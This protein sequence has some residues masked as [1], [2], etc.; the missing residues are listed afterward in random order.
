M[1]ATSGSPVDDDRIAGM[2]ERIAGAIA[3]QRPSD[4]AAA[5]RADYQVAVDMI[6]VLSDIRFRCLVF[7]TSITALANALAPSQ[8]DALRGPLGL[9]GLLA[10]LGIAVY[11]LRNSQLY[12]AAMH[13]AKFLERELQCM[14]SGALQGPAGLFT[15]RPDYINRNAQAP[16]DI[17]PAEPPLMRF[18]LVQVKHDRGLALIYG[19]ALG[20]WAFLAFYGL[21]GWCGQFLVAA[22]CLPWTAPV[23]HSIRQLSALAVG[24]LVTVASIRM[25]IDHDGERWPGPRNWTKRSL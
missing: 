9:L 10:T 22:G 19:A 6:K 11:D 20:A 25:L 16:T 14:P 18:W 24:I 12:G 8:A 3:Q 2:V 17:Q 4:P 5:L 13:R 23:L 21:A 1:G 7:V 15:E